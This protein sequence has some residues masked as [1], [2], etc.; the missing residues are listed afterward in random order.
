MCTSG[1]FGILSVLLESGLTTASTSIPWLISSA[2]SA[3]PIAP[4]GPV[5]TARFN[6]FS[7][8]KSAL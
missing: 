5:I 6:F 2:I 8:M 3:V 1:D 4:V 7:L